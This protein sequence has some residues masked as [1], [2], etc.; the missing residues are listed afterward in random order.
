M[1]ATDLDQWIPEDMAGPV[2][3]R[4]REVSA[5]ERLFNRVPMR[6]RT[7]T[8]PRAGTVGIDYVAVGGTYAEDQATDD[9]VVLTARKFGKAIRFEEEDLDDDVIGRAAT[10][11]VKQTAWARS[12]GIGLDNAVLATA[13]AESATVGDRRPFESVWQALTASTDDGYTPGA[14]VTAA[15]ISYTALSTTAGLVEGSDYFDP[16]QCS[17]IARPGARAAFRSVVDTTGRPLFVEGAGP[18]PDQLMG[19]PIEYTIGSRLPTGNGATP[20]G[21]S[22]APAGESLVFFGNWSYA[23]LGVRSGPESM[24][25]DQPGFLTDEP[26]LKMRA[27]RGFKVGTPHAFA[28][29]Q[30]A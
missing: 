11:Q 4:V 2:Q 21:F 25:S 23:H 1:A 24:L 27:R 8:I 29:L 13:G 30:F 18:L 7:R 22:V 6:T 28:V 20:E 17:W 3:T 16:S 26:I 15:A 14:N 19:Y 9:T 12:Y 5:V 10:I